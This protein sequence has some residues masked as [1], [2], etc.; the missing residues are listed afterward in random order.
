MEHRR[1]YTNYIQLFM[2]SIFPTVSISLNRPINDYLL[3][4][5]SKNKLK[6]I[7]TGFRLRNAAVVIICFLLDGKIKEKDS[8]SIW[9][10]E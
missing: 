7:C 10:L 8:V 6:N 2:T 5:V 3:S 1:F 9:R 4:T